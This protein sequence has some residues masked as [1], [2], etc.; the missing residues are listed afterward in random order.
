MSEMLMPKSVP[1][2][3]CSQSPHLWLVSSLS[4]LFNN[5]PTLSHIFRVV[6]AVW[7]ELR[8]DLITT[9]QLISS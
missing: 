2:V 1:L 3:L 6:W 5:A 7:C 8:E 9:H 4:S